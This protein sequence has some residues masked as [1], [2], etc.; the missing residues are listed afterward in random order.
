MLLLFVSF[1]NYLIDV[2]LMFAA[3]A[4]AANTVLRSLAGAASPLF[5]H[6]MFTAMG[7][8]GGG[9]LVGGVAALLAIIPF[10]FYKFGPAIRARS[11][12]S[13]QKF[14]A[15]KAAA[16]KA[17]TEQKDQQQPRDMEAGVRT[18]EEP[19]RGRPTQGESIRDDSTLIKEKV[20]Q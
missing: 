14:M 15:A 16:A 10:L 5:T 8:G 2:Y 12:F 3:S 6:Q 20:L 4:L 17:A 7:V 18:N 11:T 9:S 19:E 1:V 13:P